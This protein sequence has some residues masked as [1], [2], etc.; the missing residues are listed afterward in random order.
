MLQPCGCRG[1]SQRFLSKQFI[2]LRWRDSWWSPKLPNHVDDKGNNDKRNDAKRIAAFGQFSENQKTQKKEDERRYAATT[3]APGILCV[4]ILLL[5][6]TPTQKLTIVDAGSRNR[7]S[8]CNPS[9]AVTS[10]PKSSKAPRV[11]NAALRE[12]SEGWRSAF[13]SDGDHYSEVMSISNPN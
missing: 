13:R 4:R 10:D 1:A 2:I 8:S 9:P 12:D 5:C 6:F 11:T 7:N 3:T